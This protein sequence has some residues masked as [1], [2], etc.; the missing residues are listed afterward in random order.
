M[1]YAAAL[2]LESAMP[3]GGQW[4]DYLAVIAL[5]E[6]EIAAQQRGGMAR[7]L[8]RM[9][10]KARFFPYPVWNDA[11]RATAIDQAFLEASAI[12]K[13]GAY[14]HIAGFAPMRDRESVRVKLGLES[15][16]QFGKCVQMAIEKDRAVVVPTTTGWE[17]CVACMT[18]EPGAREPLAI[19]ASFSAD[20]MQRMEEGLLG[21]Y[22]MVA[23]AEVPCGVRM[24]EDGF[25]LMLSKVKAREL[26][27]AMQERRSMVVEG[28]EGMTL[29]CEVE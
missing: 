10:M 5:T 17:R 28:A 20:G 21:C 9:G 25:G 4:E 27:A 22:L 16:A 6:E 13:T 24:F 1:A 12:A 26:I 14:A 3:A 8:A 23:V 29:V 15:A 2:N 18:W 11:K 19:T 7:V